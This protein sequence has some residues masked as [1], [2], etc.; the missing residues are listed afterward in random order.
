MHVVQREDVQDAV[1]R[2]PPPGLDQGLDLG[3]KVSM[4]GDT[5]LGR[6]VVP[7]V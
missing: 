4:G 5:P 6:L 7:L 1:L 2:L 3:L